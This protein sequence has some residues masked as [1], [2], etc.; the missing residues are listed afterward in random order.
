TGLHVLAD[1]IVEISADDLMLRAGRRRHRQLPIVDLVPSSIVGERRVLAVGQDH[2]RHQNL[3]A[4][5][6]GPFSRLS[7]PRFG[8]RVIT[9]WAASRSKMMRLNLAHGLSR[10]TAAPP[11]G[12]RAGPGRRAR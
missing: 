5:F 12:R 7:M 11:G 8:Y 6:T 3:L 1:D 9:Q 10:P 4:D 2:P